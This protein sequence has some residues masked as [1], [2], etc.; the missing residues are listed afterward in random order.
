MW[1]SSHLVHCNVSVCG[2]RRRSS[3]LWGGR[4]TGRWARCWVSVWP[5]RDCCWMPTRWAPAEGQTHKYICHEL[6]RTGKNRN[7]VTVSDLLQ[8]KG[9]GADKDESKKKKGMNVA[10][11]HSLS[12]SILFHPFF[13]TPLSNPLSLF[14][15]SGDTFC[16][17]LLLSRQLPACQRK[18]LYYSS[19]H[20]APHLSCCKS[21]YHFKNTNCLSILLHPLHL[22]CKSLLLHPKV[23]ETQACE[24]SYLKVWLPVHSIKLCN[25]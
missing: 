11:S 13:S 5:E 9:W 17:G 16:D 25:I 10:I 23:Y 6:N 19:C 4:A 20:S 8:K 3:G 12:F 24:S 21:P 2:W 22:Y 15:S 14:L 1:R 7:N 18:P